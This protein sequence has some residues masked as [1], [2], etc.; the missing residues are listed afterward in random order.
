MDEPK[1]EK[2]GILISPGLAWVL[3][4][5][6]TLIG[7]I[8]L[9]HI[10]FMISTSADISAIREQQQYNTTI[11][12]DICDEIHEHVT[13]PS[14]HYAAMSGLQER[15]KR[16]ENEISEI[17]STLKQRGWRVPDECLQ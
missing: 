11:N 8:S 17:K 3:G 15:L 4:L 12:R 14:L 7:T 6:A 10:G 1:Q 5:I 9:F 2:D 16:I 13:D